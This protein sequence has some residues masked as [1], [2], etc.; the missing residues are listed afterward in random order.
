MRYV[1]S[2]THFGHGNVIEYSRRPFDTVEEMN[3]KMVAKWNKKVGDDDT[4]IHL[5]DVRHH[6][7]EFATHW[8]EQLNGQILLVRGNHDSGIGQNATV[9]TVNSCTIQHG[10]YQFYLEHEPVGFSSWQIHGHTHQS[11]LFMYP[12][13]NR[14][15]KTINVSVELIGYEPLALDRLVQVLDRTNER[16][17]TFK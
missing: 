9:H 5:G 2:D 13:I 15:R 8:F 7:G 12:F 10:R 17:K 11:D 3:R 1:I 16:V 14:E 6:P 4:V